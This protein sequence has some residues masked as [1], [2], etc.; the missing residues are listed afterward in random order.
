[1]TNS[2]S[3]N[4]LTLS[5]QNQVDALWHDCIDPEGFIYTVTKAGQV[6]GRQALGQVQ[7]PQLPQ[8]V[9]SSRKIQRLSQPKYLYN[10]NREN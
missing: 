5:E 8:P 3:Y 2:Y 6:T 10:R 7:S 1:M 9:Q 4:L